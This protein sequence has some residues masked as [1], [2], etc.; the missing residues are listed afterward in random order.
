MTKI[1]TIIK[2]LEVPEEGTVSDRWINNDI[3]PIEEG[4]RTWTFWTF[5]NLWVLTNTNISSYM[6]GS[7]LIALGLTWWQAII[8]IIVGA[9]LSTVFIVLNSMPGAFYHLGFPIA[10]R[11]VWG[12]Y[13]SSFVIYNRILLSLVWYAVQ[14]WIGGQCVYVCLEA[15]WPNLEDRIPNHIH[16]TGLTSATFLSYVI[17]CLISLPL[18]WIRP[19]K[20]KVFLYVGV[21]SILV[22]EV[23]LLIWALATM[24]GFGST[25]SSKP[26]IQD[27]SVGWMVLYGIISAIGGIAAGILNQ[28]DYARFAKRPRDAIWG[29]IASAATYSIISSVIGILVTA[30]TQQ[31]YGEA[32]WSLPDLLVAMM[33]AGHSRSRAAGF[34]AGAALVISQWG[35]NIP[36]NA[37]SGGFDLAAT[38]PTFINI[39]RG[40]YITALLSMVVNPWQLLAS[41]STFLAVLSS[42][43]VFL[44]PM[45]GL[46]I[47][48]YYIVN[49]RKIKV[50]DLFRGNRESVYWYT[51]GI[52]WRAPI[53]WALGV[54]PSMPGFIS[55]VNSSITVSIG[56]TRL[57]YISFLVGFSISAVTFVALHH[58]FPAQAVREFVARPETA[59]ETMLDA[60]TRWD[61]EGFVPTQSVLPKDVQDIE[62]LPKDI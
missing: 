15:I 20:L 14:S 30:A 34:F 7:S 9:I 13:G 39:R 4:R 18:I 52:N 59:K 8:A 5:H 55:N 45:I 53:A 21:A 50:D 16:A 56:W 6:T 26:A 33:R 46:M 62:T 48:S 60:Q 36:G 42:Y 47:S 61:N 2:K 57:Y 28:S 19:H 29:Q 17:F 58:F 43:G 1:Q 10:N 54:F 49:K 44:G 38:F 25:I 24:D 3:K 27:T 11:Y 32:L 41:A 31:R 37:L 35:I 51:W 40:A 23:V 12:M 22:F